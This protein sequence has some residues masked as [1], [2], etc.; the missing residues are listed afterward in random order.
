MLLLVCFKNDSD[1]GEAVT[2]T[3]RFGISILRAGQGEL[4]AQRCTRKREQGE[5]QLCDAAIVHDGGVPLLADALATVVCRVEQAV[6]AGDHFVVIGAVEDVRVI[7]EDEHPL[8]FFGGGFCS[9][10]PSAE[11]HLVLQNRR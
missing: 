1:T 7:G 2:E 3:G 11:T 10:A 6:P 9:L 5:D 8:L 4:L